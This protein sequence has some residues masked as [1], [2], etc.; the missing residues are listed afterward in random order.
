MKKTPVVLLVSG[1]AWIV[2]YSGSSVPTIE[3][4]GQEVVRWFTANASNAG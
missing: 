2:F 4:S 1:V 3:S